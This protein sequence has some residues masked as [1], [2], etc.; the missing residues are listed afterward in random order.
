MKDKPRIVK[1]GREGLE[2][3]DMI[4]SG[5]KME[6]LDWPEREPC[7]SLRRKKRCISCSKY[8]DFFLSFF[9]LMARVTT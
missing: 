1:A 2:Q 8:T 7:F 5:T 9:F 3:T 6:K 4:R